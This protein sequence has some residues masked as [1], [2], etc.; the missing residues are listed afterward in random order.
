MALYDLLVHNRE[1]SVIPLEQLHFSTE[2]LE[3]LD[4]LINEYEYA[5]ALK[6]FGLPTDNKLLLHG[7]TGCGKTATAKAIA[8]K[9]NKKI[10]ILHLGS[11]V[12]SRLGETAKNMTTV[13]NK[14][15]R[16]GA[17]LFIDEFDYI[18]KKRDFDTKDSGE[19][20][21]LV[22]TVIQLVDAL[23]PKSL[24]IA[25]TNYIESIDTALLRRFQLKLKFDLPKAQE[26]DSYYEA[27]LSN[28]P[29]HLRN[30]DRQYDISYAEAK[31]VA[32]G[33][34]KKQVIQLAQLK[35]KA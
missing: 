1:D 9:I 7:H 25:A 33:Q 17:V 24:L 12:S 19:M 15:A 6:E 32:F 26:L 14:A 35:A 3:I 20:K 11:F 2:N 29:E 22:N 4:Q 28:Y 8:E 27:I 16:E 18:G 31:N 23:P 34:L 10:I 13:F 30:I 5:E 21:R